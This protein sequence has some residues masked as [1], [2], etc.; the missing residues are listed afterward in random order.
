M[1]NLLEGYCKQI[2]NIPIKGKVYSLQ[3]DLIFG[4]KLAEPLLFL[5]NIYLEK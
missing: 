3:N 2:P 4:L 5:M 1:L